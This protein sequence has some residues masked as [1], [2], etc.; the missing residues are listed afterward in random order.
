MDNIYTSNI[1]TNSEFSLKYSTFINNK[2]IND[3][4]LSN[5]Y[6]Y[7][8]NSISTNNLLNKYYSG[9]NNKKISSLNEIEFLYENIS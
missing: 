7:K 3:N 8:Y 2:T 1:I 9:L 6:D 4:V 5:M